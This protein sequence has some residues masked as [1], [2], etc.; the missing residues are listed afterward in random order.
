MNG[1]RSSM[2]II[3]LRLLGGWI[4]TGRLFPPHY[5]L[6]V[7]Q[8]VS[9][10]YLLLFSVHCVEILCVKDVLLV[11][12][13]WDLEKKHHPVTIDER[14]FSMAPSSLLKICPIHFHLRF[15]ISIWIGS[16]SVSFHRSLLEIL[17]GHEIARLCRKQQLM[18]VWSGLVTVLVSF[19]VLL[20]NSKT[21]FTFV[22]KSCIF[23]LL[24]RFL[25]F[26]IGNN[27]TNISLAFFIPLFTSFNECPLLTTLPR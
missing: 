5:S 26:H 8:L 14:I 13:V 4:E 9:S 17:S 6:F 27:W 23:V 11:L 20:P 19:Q 16:W 3:Q 2:Q 18:K 15:L 10:I 7:H 25:F 22:L 24:E 12:V 1:V 21:D